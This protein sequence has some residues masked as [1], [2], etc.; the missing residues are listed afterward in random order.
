MLLGF[1][2]LLKNLLNAFVKCH[3]DI[4]PLYRD[5]ELGVCQL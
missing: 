4:L 5:T 1:I 3:I 2:Q